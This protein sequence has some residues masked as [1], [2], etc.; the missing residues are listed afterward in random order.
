MFFAHLINTTKSLRIPMKVLSIPFF[1]FL[2]FTGSVYALDFIETKDGG[3]LTGTIKHIT[4][5]TIILSTDYAGD[6]TL[7]RDKIVGFS[8]EQPLSVR[9]NSGTVL[10]G[11]IKHQEQGTLAITADDA[12]L[13]TQFN[14]I[15]ESWPPSEKDP[16][17]VRIEQTH[18][19][20]LRKWS[21]D[22]GVD[23]AGK[24]GNSDEFGIAINVAAE[25]AGKD[26]KLRLYGSVDKAEQEGIDS[27][28][29][30]IIGS[31]YTAYTNDPW[32][33]YAR[34]EFE[35]DD[36]EDLDLRALI[37]SGL[38]YRAFHSPEHSL[39]L[40]AG[41]GY[42]HESFN[43]G[44]TEQSPTLDFGLTHDWQF[45]SWARMKNSLTYT[46]AIDDF[47]DYLITHDSGIE[48]PLGLSD[49]WQLRIGLRNDYKSLPATNRD[50]LDTSYY[51]RLQVGW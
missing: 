33:W 38:N 5:D 24:K 2:A 31:E 21:Y 12:S 11:P 30:I 6:I 8:A 47:G 9:L 25:L 35:R 7:Q 42:R 36:F 27:S 17:I 44:S 39:E 19:D 29:E 18:T 15:S 23:I 13:F 48:I 20:S 3:T 50:N 49:Y 16:E 41:L 40:R 22:A 37:G 1:F 43:D 26:D 34:T 46:P 45:V 4:H 28:D 51:S 10:T 14:Q 32:G